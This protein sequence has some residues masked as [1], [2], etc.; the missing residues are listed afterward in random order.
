MLQNSSEQRSGTLA[1]RNGI[2]PR[3]QGR[4]ERSTQPSEGTILAAGFALAYV[5]QIL[6]G[7]AMKGAAAR[8]LSNLDT[9]PP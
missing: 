2:Y 8:S 6:V 5:H 3:D 4:K 1:E 7:S 9:I